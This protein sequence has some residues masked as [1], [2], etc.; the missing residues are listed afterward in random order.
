VFHL[1]LG[2]SGNE[3]RSLWPLRTPESALPCMILG[4]FKLSIPIAVSLSVQER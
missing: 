1:L 4:E 2:H 3:C